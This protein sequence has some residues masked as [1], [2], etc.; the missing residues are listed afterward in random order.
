MWDVFTL[1]WKKLIKRPLLWLSFI[2]LTIVFVYFMGG[3]QLDATIHVP[4]Y[5]EDLSAE[6]VQ[7]W[8]GLLNTEEGSVVFEVTDYET[9]QEAIRMNNIS[10]AME[11]T[12]ETYRFLAGREDMEIPVVNQYVNRIY[13]ERVRLEEVREAFPDTEVELNEYITVNH[14]SIA[15]M[16]SIYNEHQLTTLV[17]MTLYFTV[18]TVMFL[19]LS[20]VEEKRLGTWNR[21]IFSPLSKTKIYLGHLLHYFT[22]GV[23]QIVLSFVVLVNLMGIDLGTNYLPMIAV[24]LAFVFAIVA[25]AILVAGIS[26]TTQSLQVIIPII[27]TSMAMLGGAFWPI[28]IVSN[29][30]LLFLAELMP[31]KH[32]AE[33]MIDAVVRNYS[34]SELIQPIGILLLMGV[35]FMGIGINLMERAS[36][37]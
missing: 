33:G 11:I 22:V 10:F 27:A 13:S 29:R 3:A 2:G 16:S 26:P 37:N 5:S 35:L 1:Q 4:V 34:L 36:K 15:D 19:Q 9:A 17:G 6:E 30:I 20:L 32:A 25:L 21:L 23:L 14:T 18:F 31:L 24:A 8:V 28:D 12:D 7:E